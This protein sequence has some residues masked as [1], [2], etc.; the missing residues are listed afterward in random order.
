MTGL[1]FGYLDKDFSEMNSLY[2]SLGIIHLFALSGM[3]V[4]FFINAFRYLLLRFGLQKEWVDILQLPFSV[5]YAGLTGFSPSVIRALLQKHFG[6]RGVSGLDN[7]GVTILVSFF[8]MPHFLLHA[9]GVLSFSYAFI[10]S[11]VK[12]DQVNI[13]KRKMLESTSISLGILPLLTWYFSVFQP[14]SILLTFLFSFLFD[15]ILLPLLSLAFLISPVWRS[16]GFN[17][18]F[19]FLESFIRWL[20]SWVNS[21][22]VFGRPNLVTLLALLVFLGLLYDFRR[23]LKG[24]LII[25][26][27]IF[28]LFFQTKFPLTNEITVVD[29][30]QGDSIF[31]RDMKGQTILIDVGG[32]VNFGKPSPWQKKQTV[33]NAERTLIPYL[34]S[35]GVETIDTLILT[36]TDTDHIGDMLEVAKRFK[37]KKVLVSAGSLTV[38]SFVQKLKRM[39]APIQ[40]AEVGDRLPIFDA[41]LHVLY[42]IET[43]DGGNDDSLVLYGEFLKT[44]FLFTGD[45]EAN[46]EEKLLESYPNLRAD[47]VKVGHHGSKGSST[48]A[49]IAQLSPKVALIS[50]GKNNRYQHPHQEVVAILKQYGSRIYRT[51]QQGAIR[52]KG[53]NR[54]KVET[55]KP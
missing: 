43:G 35:R 9:G 38:A 50:A 26:A 19:I 4:G 44:S 10:L 51:D 14:V 47:V 7:L 17:S 11:F 28:L 37:I 18:L 48:D 23:N 2:S 45:L 46:G 55:V 33:S 22:I 30:G 31:L 6:N 32:R 54:W 53:Q 52:F 12:C 42:P 3:Q 15:R 24:A 8:L 5:L 13:L 41:H 25:G 40:V 34:Q 49:F 16:E 1:L 21:P 36:H 29:V 27:C 20:G 39:N